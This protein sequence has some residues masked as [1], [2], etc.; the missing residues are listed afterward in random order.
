MKKSLFLF[1]LLS[2]LVYKTQAQ[3]DFFI[4]NPSLDSSLV[5]DL[6]DTLITAY[7]NYSCGSKV[8]TLD[9][10]GNN[11]TDLTISA[12]C[13]VNGQGIG[14]SVKLSSADS[15]R[16]SV[17]TS[18]IDT[19]YTTESIGSLVY[20]PKA[21]RMVR[22]Y[23]MYDTIF[24]NDCTDSIST[25][26]SNYQYG[27]Y[28]PPGIVY[29]SLDNWISGEHYF[30]I[31]KTLRN[32]N[33]L[34]WVK[35][36]V[37][38]YYTIR[39]KSYALNARWLNTGEQYKTSPL[40]SPNPAADRL[41]IVCDNNRN[42]KLQIYSTTGGSVLQSDLN[43]GRNELDIAH[44]TAGIYIVRLTGNDVVLQQKLIKK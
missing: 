7:N 21:F 29:N 20:G 31:R 39:M 9:L 15:C 22:I 8:Y 37:L 28:P 14:Q 16:F 23:N 19:V 5:V 10:D 24:S 34:G 36:D 35:V 44:L 4:I 38:N 27:K 13:Y 43:P 30:G 2:V 12:F 32:I 41:I 33:Y 17:D 11:I 18:V 26:F 40:L 6:K 25:C 42:L 1:I 3:G